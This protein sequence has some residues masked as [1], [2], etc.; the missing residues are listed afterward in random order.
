MQ[1][2]RWT[3]AVCSVMLLGMACA[4]ALSP[5]DARGPYDIAEFE[6]GLVDA[7]RNRSMDLRVIYPIEPEGQ[8]VSQR[9]LIVFNHGFLLAAAGYRSYGEHLASHGFVVAMPTFP[10]TF[11]NVHHAKLAQDIRFVIDHVLDASDDASHP[12]YGRV[13]PARIG[14]SGHS[15]GGKLSLLEAATDERI[16]SAAVLDPVDEGNPLWKDLVRY[17][18][19]APE[20]MPDLHIPLLILGAELGSRLVTFSPCA[21]EDENYKRFY[22]AANPPAI[23]VTQ[24]DVGHGQYV[25]DAADDV[26]DPCAVGDVSAEWVRASSVSY[27]SAF[28]LATLDES[29]EAL[30]WLDARLA[31]DEADG[32]IRVRRK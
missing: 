14:A 27:L 12:L 29:A 10:M 5:P 3:M 15:L 26:T 24:I 25:D 20:L 22:E 19:V 30:A 7:S 18:S 28:F 16:R 31:G 32:R 1:P 4:A 8:E 13:D 17:P 11:L 21:P 6:T 23:E 2:R 9:A